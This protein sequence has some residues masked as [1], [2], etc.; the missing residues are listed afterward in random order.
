MKECRIIKIPNF[1][2]ERGKMSVLEADEALPF[3]PKRVFYI[4]DVPANQIRG[5]HA[6]TKTKFVMVAIKGSV[7]VT[8]SNGQ[9]EESFILDNPSK[10]LFLDSNTW[11][12]MSDFSNDSALLVIASAKYDK[13]EYI[14]DFEMFKSRR[15]Q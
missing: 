7:K 6:N 5:Q 8:V 14:T 13:E 11:K 12:T 2:D 4:Y 9:E 10:G 1:G 3:S 15:K